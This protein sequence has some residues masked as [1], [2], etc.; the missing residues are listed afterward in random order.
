MDVTEQ[1]DRQPRRSALAHSYGPQR[2][3]P[4]IESYWWDLTEPD[5]QPAESSSAAGPRSPSREEGQ[6]PPPRQ[7][8]LTEEGSAD[9]ISNRD[10]KDNDE[11]DFEGALNKEQSEKRR[12]RDLRRGSSRV[13]TDPITYKKIRIKNTDNDIDE[14]Y[15]P[16]KSRGT[17]TLNRAFP[18]VEWDRAIDGFRR[19]MLRYA[20]MGLLPALVLPRWFG[21]WIGTCIALVWCGGLGFHFNRVG[22]SEWLDHKWDLERRRAQGHVREQHRTE[23]TTGKSGS[24]DESR[25]LET[26]GGTET[27]IQDKRES[28]EWMNTLLGGLWPIIDPKCTF[29]V[30]TSKGR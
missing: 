2:P 8:T 24:K 17:N 26:V 18:P 21:F 22:T 10:H 23:Q 19:R 12:K 29:K 16:K 9:E 25:K 6:I 14:A 15:D 27:G 7:T 3:V 4:Q 1:A 30:C 11:S 5:N 28:V 13:V 20:A